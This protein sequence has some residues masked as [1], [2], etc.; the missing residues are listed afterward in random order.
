M[1]DDIVLSPS[2]K[3]KIEQELEQLRGVEMPA[4][5]E[6]IRQARDLGDLS[7]NFDY[8]D[9]KR[10]QGFIQGRI[11]DLQAMLERARVIENDGHA[12][13]TCG[14]GSVV[15]L[16]DLED[17]DESQITLVG[18]Y[19]A[20][21]PVAISLTSPLGKALSGH[22]AGETVRITVNAYTTQYVIVAVN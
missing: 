9:S 14:L 1:A 21:P 17:N 15:T 3:R 11:A 4:L 8:Q 6:R 5:S 7:E 19:E 2:G 18:D 13:G 10:Q 22:T 12:E 20:D 16:R